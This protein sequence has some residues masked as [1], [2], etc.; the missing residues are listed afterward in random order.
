MTNATT[1][2]F[3]ASSLTQAQLKELSSYIESAT[4][5]DFDYLAEGMWGAIVEYARTLT[6][7]EDAVDTIADELNSICYLNGVTVEGLN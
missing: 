2:T 3:K 4:H 6:D 5:K 7:D 1:D